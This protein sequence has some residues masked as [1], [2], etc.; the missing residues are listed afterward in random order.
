M[1]KSITVGATIPSIGIESL[2][3]IMIPGLPIEIQR[4]IAV[5]Y[6][7]KVDEI[8]LYKRKLQRAYE[9]LSHIYDN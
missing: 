1:L 6:R 5:R 8:E 7:A 3:K 9:E 4:E 2:K